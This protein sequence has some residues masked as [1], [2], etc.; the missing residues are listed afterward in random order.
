LQ[1]WAETTAE[2]LHIFLG[3]AM[4]MARVKKLSL[5]EYWPKDQILNYCGSVGS[6]SFII[7]ILSEFTYLIL[8][9]IF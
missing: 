4:L 5:A 3:L 7:Y 8:T 2:E 9:Q 6:G 1:S